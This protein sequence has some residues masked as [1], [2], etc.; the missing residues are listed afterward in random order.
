MYLW[1]RFSMV[2]LKPLRC[3]FPSL[4]RLQCHSTPSV[5]H[6]P[7]YSTRGRTN[8]DRGFLKINAKGQSTQRPKIRSICCFWQLNPIQVRLEWNIDRTLKNLSR[9]YWGYSGLVFDYNLPAVIVTFPSRHVN[10]FW[11]VF[12]DMGLVE[13]PIL[14]CQ[15]TFSSWLCPIIPRGWPIPALLA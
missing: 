11:A 5:S 9:T 6:S 13:R 4:C 10:V 1:M 3:L 7:L 8:R 14:T 15:P 2:K 12:W